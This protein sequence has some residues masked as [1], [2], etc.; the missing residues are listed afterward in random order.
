MSVL[1]LHPKEIQAL[2]SQ[3]YDTR[4]TYYLVHRNAAKG[5][6]NAMLCQHTGYARHNIRM[7][8]QPC[9][10]GGARHTNVYNLQLFPVV[11]FFVIPFIIFALIFS[12]PP[13]RNADP[14]SHRSSPPSPSKNAALPPLLRYPLIASN[15]SRHARS[16]VR[17]LGAEFTA[18]SFGR[19]CFSI[20]PRLGHAKCEGF[21]LRPP[22]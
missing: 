15:C 22:L 1:T 18:K 13:S 20:V 11:F 9:N 8:A 12:L 14:G 19:L 7:V 5:V 2:S 16:V 21:L 17:R 10:R 6:G 3:N 4:D